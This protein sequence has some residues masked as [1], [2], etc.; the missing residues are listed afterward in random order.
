M[1]SGISILAASQGIPLN[2]SGS[3]N[4][5]NLQVT[6]YGL[7]KDSTEQ[8]IRRTTKK[9][10]KSALRLLKVIANQVENLQDQDQNVEFAAITAIKT[11]SLNFKEDSNAISAE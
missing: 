3:S 7:A 8:N 4:N 11:E 1:K 6:N 9:F 2:L 10:N 5:G